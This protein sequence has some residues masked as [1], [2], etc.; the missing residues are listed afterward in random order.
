MT[1]YFIASKQ[2]YVDVDCGLQ[3]LYVAYVAQYTNVERVLQILYIG[4]KQLS[5]DV[6][7]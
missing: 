4:Y 7:Q 6:G 2:Q 1:T 3:T 5:A